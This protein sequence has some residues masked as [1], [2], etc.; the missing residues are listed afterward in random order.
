MPYLVIVLLGEL[1]VGIAIEGAHRIMMILAP[2]R[3]AAQLD[4]KMNRS[5]CLLSGIQAI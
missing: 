1:S 2:L 4:I 5:Y 3:S